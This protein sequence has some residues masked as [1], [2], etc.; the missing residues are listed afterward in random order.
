MKVWAAHLAGRILLPALL[1]LLLSAADAGARTFASSAPRGQDEGAPAEAMVMAGTIPVI[2]HEE[3]LPSPL[4]WHGRSED[5]LVGED[6]PWI[7][8]AEES[9]LTESPDYET[10][11]AWLKNLVQASDRLRMISI[12]TS[13]EQREIWMVVASEEGAATAAE[14]RANGRPTLLAQAGIHSGEIDGKDAGM[15]LLRDLTVEGRGGDLLQRVNFLFI[16]ILSVDAHEFSSAH[17]RINQR[18]PEHQGWRTNARNLNLNR[19]YAKLDTEEIR[20][21][22]GILRDWPVDLYMDIHV[23]DGADYQYDITYG[24]NGR[25]GWSPAIGRWLEDVFRPAVDRRMWEMGHVPGPLVFAVEGDIGKGIYAWTASP[26]FSQGY[27]DARH[28]PTLLVE[29]HSLKDY[30]RRVLGT[31]VLLES[32][33]RQLAEHGGELRSAVAEDRSRRP[34]RLATSWK[35]PEGTPPRIGFLAVKWEKVFSPISGDSVVRWLGEPVKLD[36]PVL[37]STEPAELVPR[38]RAYWISGVWREIIERLALHGVQME[39]LDVPRQ[40]E[41]EVDSLVEVEPARQPYE[42]HQRMKGEVAA[43]RRTVLYP[44]GSVRISTDQDLGDLVVLLL[45]PQASDS[46]FQ[47]GFFPEILQRAEY[48]EAYVMEPMARRMLDASPELRRAFREKLRDDPVFAKDPRARLQWFY[49]KTP[50]W[51]RRWRIIPVGREM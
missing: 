45:Q 27:G 11:V 12:G 18:G 31:R 47:W 17:S 46:F 50:Y 2:D 19:D 23:T 13:G 25:Q 20:A 29:N 37:A 21:V 28:V 5:L 49:E 3:V 24:G 51:D 39:T 1:G 41:V 42:G 10:T 38:P 26:R 36:I 6:D 9:G 7:T 22:V 14:L 35:V 33:L 44:P 43:V 30:R 16:P 48:F 40:V 4:P 32:A 15:M 8:P 34:S